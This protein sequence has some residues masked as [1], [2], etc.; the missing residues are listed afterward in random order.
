MTYRLMQGDVRE[1][2]AGL[3]EEH[4][5]CCVTSPPYWGLRSYLKAGDPLKASELGSEATP[6]EYVANLVQVFRE[7][8]RVLRR[9]GVCFVNVADTYAANRTYQVPDGKWCDVGNSA[10]SRVPP[11]L[12]PKSLCLIPERLALALQEDGWI[13]RSRIA[14]TKGSAMPESVR[15]RPTCVWEHIWMMSREARYYC[16]ME[17]VRQGNHISTRKAGGY[18]VDDPIRHQKVTGIASRDTTTV[19]ANL[20]NHWHINPVAF[21]GAHFATYPP[22]IPRRC[23]LMGTS[24]KGCCPECG[25]PW[26]RVV[27]RSSV[28]RSNAAK[29]GNEDLGGKGHATDQVRENHD[30]RNGPTSTSTTTGWRPGCDHGLDPVPCRVLDPFAGTGTSLMVAEQLGR[31]SVGIELSPSYIEM[32]E[33]RIQAGLPVTQRRADSRP[34]QMELT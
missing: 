15:D 18:E 5:H 12:K 33:R 1:V 9:D 8:R 23:I 6:Q 29:A 32:A 17:A 10:A 4:F 16:D 11:G 14:W 27:E 13:I 30:I 2:L 25:K 7:V 28:N 21:P 19:G 20:R 22:E 34:F 26:E 31:D 24:A 3:P